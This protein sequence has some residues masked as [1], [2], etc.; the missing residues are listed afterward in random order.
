M[1]DQ[2][3]MYQE[4]VLADGSA[5]ILNENGVIEA[6][7]ASGNPAGTCTPGDP[8]WASKASVFDLAPKEPG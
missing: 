1:S 7:D 5:V 8:D 3:F 2:A 6:Y 4:K